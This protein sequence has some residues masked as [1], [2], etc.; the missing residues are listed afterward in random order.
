MKNG[1]GRFLHAF[2]G[3]KIRF[4][5]FI[6]ICAICVGVTY[7]LTVRSERDRIGGGDNYTQA[8]KYLEIKNVLDKYYVDD[9]NE[10]AVS[11]AAFDAMVTGLGDKWSDYMSP[12]DYEAYKLYS[13]NQYTG[14][15]ITMDKDAETGGFVVQGVTEDSP[16]AKA[17]IEVGE[18]ILAVAGQDI[19]SLTIGD[20]HSF[21]NS[22]LSASVSVKLLNLE[23]KESA[24]NVDC[25][26]N[27]TNPVSYKMLE[28]SVGYVRILSFDAGSGEAAIAAVDKLLADGALGF[29]FDVRTNP[30]GI[31]EEMLKLLDYLL[32]SGDILA[33]VD[34]EGNETVTKSDNVC[35][36][37][38][39]A[40]L[41]NGDS[42][43]AS[44]FFAASLK[45]YNWATIVGERTT[46]KG[47]SQITIELTDGSA[48]VISNGKY[49]TPTRVDLSAEG[50]LRP[51]IDVALTDSGD[52]QLT[53][54]LTEVQWQT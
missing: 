41:V 34:S 49:L 52:E 51:D 13:S 17:G 15:G 40:V 28:G 44:E 48:V 6:L 20:A 39:M 33:Y 10:E 14:L 53:A 26:A 1:F 43:A 30:G 35:L 31:Y 29:V 2:F 36:D 19:T 4:W 23:G 22:N 32:P 45:E 3:I 37:L 11:S 18:I 9:V 24:V 42:Y 7:G 5:A 16:A 47:R 50:G 8:M 21:I 27:Y 12:S 38:P 46:G 25:S 54:A